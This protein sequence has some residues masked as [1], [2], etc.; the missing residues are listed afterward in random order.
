[1]LVP[2]AIVKPLT[3]QLILAYMTPLVLVTHVNIVKHEDDIF[4]LAR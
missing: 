2:A 1:M 4:A 3:Q